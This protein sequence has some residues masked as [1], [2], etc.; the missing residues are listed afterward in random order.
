MRV[1]PLLLFLMLVSARVPAQD[2]NELMGDAGDTMLRMLPHLYD[3]DPDRVALQENLIRLEYLFNQAAPHLQQQG[4]GSRVTFELMQARLKDAVAMGERRNINLLRSAVS[5][6][7]EL[8]SSCHTQ[9]KRGKR[10]FGVSRIRELDE[11][12]AAEFSFLT[13]DYESALTSFDNYFSGTDR[14]PR[15]DLDAMYRIMVIAAEVYADP[16]LARD[17]LAAVRPKLVTGSTLDRTAAA[18]TGIFSRLAA[19]TDSLQSPRLMRSARALDAFLLN[20]W[21]AIQSTLDWNEQEAYWIVI[22]GELNRFLNQGPRAD[23]IPRL[24]YWLAVS[25]RALHYRFYN[26]LSRGYLE[27]CILQ[28]ADH[29]Y[30]RRCLDEYEMLVLVSFS[31]SGGT[32]IPIEVQQRLGELR[33]TLV[34]A[35]NQ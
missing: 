13:R 8:C 5:D 26:S 12:S 15:R 16:A 14:T 33:R 21:P 22:R 27:Q 6:A 34:A 4:E 11:Y 35:G 18:W 9:D 25:D 30:A 7:F 1:L 31:G 23:D 19:E 20:E 24:L 2:I 10:A 3:E 17:R 32:N 29:P 28:H